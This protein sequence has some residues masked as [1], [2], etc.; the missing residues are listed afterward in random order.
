MRVHRDYSPAEIYITEN[1]SAWDDVLENGSVNDKSRVSYLERHLDATFAAQSQGAPVKGYFAWSLMDNFEWAFGYGKRFGIVH[2][3]YQT[4][5]RTP[6][7][8]AHYYRERI[9]KY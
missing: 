5:K 7:S 9:S 1:G 4:Q 6:K 2:V 3:D 8:S